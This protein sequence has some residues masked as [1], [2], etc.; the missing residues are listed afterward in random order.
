MINERLIELQKDYARKLL[1]H[2]NPYT[3]LALADDPAVITVQ[4]NNEE[5]AIKEQRS[6]SMLNI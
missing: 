3:G 5:S 2:V 4:I 1:L 6:W